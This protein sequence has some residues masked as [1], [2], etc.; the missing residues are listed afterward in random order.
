M[1]VLVGALSCFLAALYVNY[2]ACIIVLEGRFSHVRNVFVT[3]PGCS[4]V[5]QLTVEFVICLLPI[6]S[7]HVPW[8]ARLRAKYCILRISTRACAY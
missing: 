4:W 8:I 7:T 6:V 3:F 1:G 5:R 2:Q